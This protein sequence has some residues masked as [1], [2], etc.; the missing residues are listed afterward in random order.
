MSVSKA[1]FGHTKDG[2]PVFC[3]TL[4]NEHG[5]EVRVL[6]YGAA[7]QSVLVPSATGER[8]DVLLGYDTV[9][10]YEERDGFFGALVGR[11]ANRLRKARFVLDGETWQLQPN[12]GANHLH[13]CFSFRNYE[14]EMGED[15]LT[16]SFLSPDGEEGYPGNLQVT[17]RYTLTA[18]DR[19]VLDYQA[20]TDRAT[21]LNLTNHA[22]WNLSGHDSGSALDTALRMDCSRFTETDAESLLTGAVLPVDGTPFDFRTPKPLER[23]IGADHPMLRYARGYD[24]NL[25]TDQPSMERPVATAY[26]PRTGIAMDYYTTQPGT[27]LYSGNF[28]APA[29]PRKGKGGVLYGNRQGFCL[30]SQHFPCAPDFPHFDTTVLR[31]GEVYRQSAA[32]RF[33]VREKG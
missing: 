19:L 25:L 30:E 18:D 29:A 17:Y 20:T 16:F 5:V 3:Y 14:G 7:L 28:I 22:Y 4:T 21:I 27:Q 26:S 12:E 6:S 31:P 32:Y 23:D 15:S 2:Q 9:S 1:L 24:L 13:G 8:V 10:E 33:Y 11:F